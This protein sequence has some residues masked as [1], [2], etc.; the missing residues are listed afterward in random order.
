MVEAV[1]LF[2]ADEGPGGEQTRAGVAPGNGKVSVAHV[3]QVRV[4]R[5]T[6]PVER[7]AYERI[8]KARAERD[9]LCPRFG[10][11][12]Q[13]LLVQRGLDPSRGEG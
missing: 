1:V 5:K 8:D 12:L 9:A 7:R 11:A 3:D 4:A 10:Q 2:G 13:F 6:C